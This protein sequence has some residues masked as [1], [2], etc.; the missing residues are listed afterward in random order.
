MSTL[1]S[2]RNLT[3]SYPSSNLFEGVAIHIGEGERMGLIGPNGAGKSTLLKILAGLEEPDD[4]EIIRQR[5]LKLVYVE[6]D[7]RFPEDATA[8]T[9]TSTLETITICLLFT[10]YFVLVT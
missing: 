6:Q 5:G 2:A 8:M 4:G 1:V 7:D 9:R 3:K 10:V